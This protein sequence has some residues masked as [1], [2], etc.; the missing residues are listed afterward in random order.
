MYDLC[1]HQGVKYRPSYIS[2]FSDW[3]TC[4]YSFNHGR[5]IYNHIPGRSIVST[6]KSFI[7]Y[8]KPKTNERWLQNTIQNFSSQSVDTLW[9]QN[10]FSAS[11]L[12]QWM[13]EEVPTRYLLSLHI[14]YFLL[15]KHYPF[16]WSVVIPKC[17]VWSHTC[18]HEQY[19]QVE[20]MWN[21]RFSAWSQA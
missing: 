14:L 21:Q 1:I 13:Q 7:F 19:V 12:S 9:V 20:C 10:A 5:S 16:V 18:K 15:K 11:C 6:N 8:G 17:L 4:K 2:Q 3:V